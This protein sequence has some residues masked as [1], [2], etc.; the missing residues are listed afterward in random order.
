MRRFRQS[1]RCRSPRAR[2]APTRSSRAPDHPTNSRRRRTDHRSGC[3]SQLSVP[4]A[5]LNRGQPLVPGPRLSQCR[6]LAYGTTSSLSDSKRRSRKHGETCSRGYDF[7]RRTFD[8]TYHGD[9]CVEVSA[10][11]TFAGWETACVPRIGTRFTMIGAQTAFKTAVPNKRR[12]STSW[13][14]AVPVVPNTTQRPRL[15][16]QS[17]GRR[18]GLIVA[19]VLSATGLAQNV[20]IQIESRR[21]SHRVQ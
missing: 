7:G 21:T 5:T 20:L 15:R 3:P 10:N 11:R 17:P 18:R 12:N 14:P 1:Q 4:P 6:P 13:C 2:I 8:T 16:Y 9:K 19:T